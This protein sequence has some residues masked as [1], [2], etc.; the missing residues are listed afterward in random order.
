MSEAD[1][2]NGLA[3]ERAEIISLDY[4]EAMVR[5]RGRMASDMR[6]A[7]KPML[8]VEHEG[9]RFR[10]PQVPGPGRGGEAEGAWVAH[11]TIPAWLEPELQE[12]GFLVAGETIV[13]LPRSAGQA[14][15]PAALPAPAADV[16]AAVPV[17][18]ETAGARAA[19]SARRRKRESS[20]QPGRSRAVR[21]ETPQEPGEAVAG[22]KGLLA[23]L[24][25]LE[26]ELA[27]WQS[28]PSGR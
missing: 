4:R 28:S 20:P 14:P 6:L 26:E 16:P 18:A 15:G 27:E 10:F 3:L 24:R 5:V 2:L 23:E 13:P 7:S 11:F 12:H 8:L 9:R 17:T 19:P 21:R 25:Q 1:A 22:V